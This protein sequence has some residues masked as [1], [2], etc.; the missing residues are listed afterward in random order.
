MHPSIKY[1]RDI[2]PHDYINIKGG[3][4][5]RI[6]KETNEC[7][8]SGSSFQFGSASYEQLQQCINTHKVFIVVHEDIQ[9]NISCNYKFI[10]RDDCGE[11]FL[12]S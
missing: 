2:V 9:N 7:I 4:F 5:Y 10:L 11:S 1:H 12:L 8:F 6:N 3:G